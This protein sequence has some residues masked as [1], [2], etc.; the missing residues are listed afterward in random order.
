MPRTTDSRRVEEARRLYL[1]QGLTAVQVAEVIDVDERTVRRWLGPD[2][3][4][5]GPQASERD[6]WQPAV[7]R[8]GYAGQIARLGDLP[9]WLLRMTEPW[10]HCGCLV[11]RGKTDDD[12]YGRA[13]GKLVHREAWKALVGPIADEMTLDHVRARGCRSPACWAPWHLEEVTAAE[14]LRRAGR[15][16][17]S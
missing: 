11:W 8:D 10:W 14:N 6:R 5:P 16:G 12:G 17:R 9:K 7:Q 4:S 3:R 2:L 13:G 1:D 15:T